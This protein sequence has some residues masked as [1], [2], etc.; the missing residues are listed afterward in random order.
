MTPKTD[1]GRAADRGRGARLAYRGF[2]Y[3][4][5]THEAKIGPIGCS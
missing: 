3:T 5:E 4:E 1:R 2:S